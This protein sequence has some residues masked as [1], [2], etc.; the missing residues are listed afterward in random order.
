MCG[1]VDH[2]SATHYIKIRVEDLS[3][4]PIHNS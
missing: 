1:V 2:S 4:N 3:L